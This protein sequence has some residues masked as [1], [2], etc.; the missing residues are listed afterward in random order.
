VT[1]FGN[2]DVLNHAVQ[3]FAA[4]VSLKLKMLRHFIPKGKHLTNTDLTGAFVE[5]LVRGIIRDWITPSLLL[6]GTC[7]DQKHQDSGEKPLQIDGIVYDPS[8]GPV[9][10]RECDFVVVHPAFC[11]GVIEIKMSVASI[12][13]FENRLQEIYGRFFRHRT[14]T[15]VM[16]VLVSH[17][18]PVQASIVAKEDG[19]E[20]C[21][22][23]DYNVAQLCPIFVLFKETD[24]G[25]FVPHFEAITG[26]VK[27]VYNNLSVSMSYIG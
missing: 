27:A 26:L 10:F 22:Y 14:T 12:T 16:G 7:Y 2:E 8:K 15:S 24:D 9:T 17:K 3:A 18:D 20:V 11:G 6:H 1:D 21:K 25:D 5:E 19:S 23:Y 13:D 4:T